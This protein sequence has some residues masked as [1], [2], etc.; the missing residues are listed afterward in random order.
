M[1]QVDP[2]RSVL[3]KLQGVRGRDGRWTAHCPAHD[4]EE[5][6]L[7]VGRGEDGRALVKCFAGCSAEQVM[8][9]IGLTMADLFS[10]S[11]SPV[12]ATVDLTGKSSSPHNS[13]AESAKK[14]E[15]EGVSIPPN[16]TAPVQLSD[17][18][19]GVTVAQYANAKALPL[20]L[21]RGLGLTDFWYQGAPAV[22][23]P[24]HDVGGQETAVQFRLALGGGNRFRWKSG[25]KPC[26]YGLSRL[27]DARATGTITLVEGAS[28]CHTLWAHDIPALGIPGAASWRE[29]RD[30]PHLEGIDTI[31]VVVE[32][33]KGGE[34]IK[35]WLATSSIRDR[36]HLVSLRSFKDPSE[37]HLD[38]PD[39]FKER[40]QAA[41]EAAVP[42]TKY[43]AAEADGRRQDAW[44]ACGELA[45][46]PGI[47]ERFSEAF[48]RQGVVGE[49][50]G[51]QLLFLALVSRLGGRPVSVVMK[52][53]SSGGK[54]I[55]VETVLRFFPDN[56]YYMLSAMSER[57]LAYS[58]EP[59]A[60]RFLVFHETAG[61]RSDFANY[62]MRSLLS[63]GHIRYETVEKTADGLKPR[64]INREGP[65]GLL[66]TT[67]AARLH[68]ENETRLLSIP[69]NG[70][71]AQTAN[72]F[73]ALADERVHQED[74]TAW[75]ALQTWL[76]GG[77]QRVTIPWALTLAE[78]VPP[79]TVRLRRDFHT[80]L[81]LIHAH[82]LLHQV[83]RDRDPDGR[84]VAN[85]DDDYATV[86][87]LAADLVAEG[88]EATVS[89]TVRE[90]VEAVNNIIS[91]GSSEASVAQVAQHL[92]L[93]KSA[94]SRRARVARVQ[95]YLKN[96]EDR[97]GRP[98][99]L[100]LGDPLPDDI[101]ILPTV[102][103]L[104]DRCCSVAGEMEE[105][106]V[107]PLPP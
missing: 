94:T 99:R 46:D 77:E 95:G 58:E 76:E 56:A 48:R 11:S 2:M 19:A 103:T 36:V 84:I 96:L 73:L 78:L 38:D 68:P 92:K 91:K 5:R 62:L 30:A 27:Q 82:A 107:P 65:T 90:T 55:I 6:S 33:D 26:L 85:I 29:E 106:T 8:E 93:D 57:A 52:G 59:L 28:D 70:T 79:L 34:A 21:L 104:K 100:V 16:G 66:V 64:V 81:T 32:P 17:T 7:S 98:A 60:H 47:L 86:R 88:A 72:I 89:H 20:D 69:V 37:L 43:A 45:G 63:E 54:S 14:R 61:L 13:S 24:N 3:H 101:T 31:Y 23:I 42:W 15:G 80:V 97:K 83:R 9:G 40:W 41:L 18:N 39:R 12:N 22:R 35:E 74:L 49:E 1:P 44:G 75:H 102:Q 71:P 105:V 4:D 51:A 50:Q 10:K 67:T 53:P 25:S 87:E